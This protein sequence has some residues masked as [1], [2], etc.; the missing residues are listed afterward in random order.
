MDNAFFG[1]PKGLEFLAGT[2]FWERFS[3]Y[4]MRAILLYYMVATAAK[5]GLGLSQTTGLSVMAIY[6]SLVYLASVTGGFISDRILGSRRTVFFGGIL[7]MFGHIALSIPIGLWGLFGSIAL[8]TT[9]TGLLKPNI[10]DMVGK[11]YSS[12]DQR[13][14]SAFTIFTFA[15]NLGAFIAPLICGWTATKFD[16]HVGFS[17]AAFG[18]FIGLLFYYFGGNKTLGKDGLVPTDPIKA[19]EVKKITFNVIAGI[20]VFAVIIVGMYFAKI[21]TL[22]NFV[23]LLSLI[24]VITPIVYFFI[25][26]R[27]K[28]ITKIERSRVLA[29]IPLFIGA[30]VFWAIEESGSSILAS[31]AL[32]QTNNNLGW[33]HIDPSWYQSLNPL[34]IMLYTPLFVLLWTKLGKRQPSTPKKFAYGL[35]FAGL[36][37]LLMVIPLSMFGVGT[38]ISPLWLVGSWAIIEIGEMLISPIGLS[39][40]TKLAPKAFGAQMV[41]MWFLADAAGQAVNSQIARFYTPGTETAYFGIIG[42]V[43]IVASIILLFFVKPVVKLMDGVK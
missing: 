23:S 4:G 17:L 16:Y 43:A 1:Q 37:F 34:F 28:K 15:I 3:Y 36:S 6:G 22:D 39:V 18:M 42:L 41:S 14:E 27:S 38:K 20:I 10:S 12:E 35:F 13:R 40:T 11:L 33:L 32:T 7:I 21:L 8:I 2:E 19:N 30:L 9:G 31:F 5:G 26:I 29:Y 25:I 24:A